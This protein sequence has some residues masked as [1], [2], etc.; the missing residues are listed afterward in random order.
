MLNEY[1][2]KYFSILGDSISTFEGISVPKESAHYDMPKKLEANILTVSDTWWGQVA[3]SLEMQLLVNNSISGS[4]VTWHPLYE[5][6]S[7]G[8]SDKRTST[9]DKEG[10][11]P[12]VVMVWLGTNDFGNAI[13]VEPTTNDDK[14]NLSIFSIAYEKMLEKL[15]KNY[16]N[17]EIW[18]FTLATSFCSKRS[19]FDFPYFR[20]GYHV[21]EYCQAIKNCAKEYGCKVIE[22]FE[23]SK[24]YDTIDGFHPNS[25]GMKTIAEMVLS[26]LA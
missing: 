4:T 11:S 20:C 8:C 3:D 13:K 6:D 14:G 17:A 18:C 25:E 9:L 1:K 12:D 5:Y 7:Y 2:G 16:P 15:K 21:K 22:L 26:N 10:V 23:N 24:P 19:D